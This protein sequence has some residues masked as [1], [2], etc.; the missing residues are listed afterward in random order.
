MRELDIEASKIPASQIGVF[1]RNMFCKS[2]EGKIIEININN[3]NPRGEGRPPPPPTLRTLS[4]VTYSPG[5]KV[6]ERQLSR[7]LSTIKEYKAASCFLKSKEEI[8]ERWLRTPRD[9]TVQ[10]YVDQVKH[11]CPGI[12][13]NK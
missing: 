5:Y 12:M 4:Y 6:K 2:Q 7:A 8:K 11:T 9:F 1:W 13:C 10:L 3:I